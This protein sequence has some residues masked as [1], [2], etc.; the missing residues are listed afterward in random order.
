MSFSPHIE[1]VVSPRILNFIKRNLYK[2]STSTKSTTY[3]SLMCPMLEYA[4]SVWDP[5]LLKHIYLIDQVER[6]AAHGV[7]HNYSWYSSVTSMQQ[8]LN[9]PTLQ[10]RHQR[11]RLVLFHKTMQNMIALQVP[12]HFNSTHGS[13]RHHNL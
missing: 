2:C 8:E 5:H 1:N 11:N 10:Q 9:W 7:L 3:S 13:T 4:S 6:R 12:S